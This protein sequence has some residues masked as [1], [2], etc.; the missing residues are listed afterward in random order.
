MKQILQNLKTGELDIAEVPAPVVL[1]GSLLI[2]TRCSLISAGTERMMVEFGKANLFAKA[3]QQPDKVK[4]VLDKI[5]TDGLMPTMETVFSRLDEPMPLGYCNS[6]VVVEVGAGVTGFQPGDRVVSNGSHAEYVCVPKNLCAKIPD[7]VTDEQAAF[8]VISSIGLQGIRL[9]NATLG[10]K[11]VIFGIGLIGL[12][13]VQL[14]R[15]QG[16]DVM[17]VDIN[18]KRL[19]LAKKYGVKVVNAAAGGDVLKAVEA[20]TA[21]KGVDGVLITASAKTDEIIHQ[22]A[23]V[24]RK[25]GTIV[26]VGVIG[27][28]LRRDDFYKKEISFQVSCSYGPGRYDESYEQ[29]GNDYPIG[30]VRWTEQRNFEAVLHVLNTK[31]LC[32]EGLIT[33]RFDQS[34]AA[35]AYESVTDDP[36]TLGVILNYPAEVKRENKVV[37]KQAVSESMNQAVVGVIGAGNFSKMILVPA[38]SK[39]K[40]RIAYIADLNAAYAK[41]LAKKFNAENAVTDYQLILKDP[42]VNTVIIAVRH[43]LHARFVCEALDAGKHVFVEKPLAMDKEQLQQIVDKTNQCKGQQV[44]VGFNR[45]FSSH[46]VKAKEL[47]EGRSEPLCMN[48]TVNAGSIPADHWV[49]HP[50]FGGGR[51]IGEACHFMDLLAF[52]ADSQVTAVSAMMIGGDVAIR[53]DKMSIIMTLQDGSVATVN[54]FANGIKSYPKEKIEIFSDSRV[55][56]M[57]NFRK[58]TGY[59]FRGFAKFKTSRQ[60]KGHKAEFAALVDLVAKGGEPLIPLEQLVNITLASFAAVESAKTG[61]TIEL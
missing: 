31:Q 50:V 16:C 55:L 61:Q 36:S 2:Q 46:I 57:D 38:L 13:A 11:I 47:L 34:D 58:L 7:D 18:P 48:M 25:R 20:W 14:L 35:S 3:R 44:M 17:G 6:G 60:D 15:A 24:C 45:R 52:I 54:Y 29:G 32:V 27:L 42:Q 5:R 22:A 43:D 9:L 49:H 56:L 23:Q 51:I 53:D 19:E 33:D 1:P 40:A 30:Y 37:V 39:T 28:K 41:H 12:L 4:Q 8:T 10:E 26:L 59:G 21:G